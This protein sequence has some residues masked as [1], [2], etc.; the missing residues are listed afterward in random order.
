MVNTQSCMMAPCSGTKSCQQKPKPKPK[1]KPKPKPQGCSQQCTQQTKALLNSQKKQ[2][3]KQ[4]KRLRKRVKRRIR[5][6]EKKLRKRLQRRL[7]KRERKLRR[8]IRRRIAHLLQNQER[9][10]CA[11]ALY[12][13]FA[14][15]AVQIQ[16]VTGAT[17]T[18]TITAP[19]S[20][21]LVPIRTPEGMI[22]VPCSSINS[23]SLVS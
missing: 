17:I 8:E 18:G 9:M 21:E 6:R 22:T 10:S 15:R 7:R 5:A 11:N 13:M 19:L 14:G 16:T 23:I 4:L 2:V 1:S 3:R 12:E 20:P